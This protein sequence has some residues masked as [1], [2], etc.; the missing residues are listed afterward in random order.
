MSHLPETTGSPTGLSP[1]AA[2]AF[3]GYFMSSTIGYIVIAIAAHTLVW[4]WRPW[5][6]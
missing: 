1:E 4:F 2:K 6:A 3:H 5:F